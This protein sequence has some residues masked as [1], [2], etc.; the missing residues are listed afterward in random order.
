MLATVQLRLRNATEEISRFVG[1]DYIVINDSLAEATEDIHPADLAVT[2]QWASWGSGTRARERLTFSLWSKK[3]NHTTKLG[4]VDEARKA[5][6]NAVRLAP[7]GIYRPLENLGT[8]Y[9]YE[10][11]FDKAIETYEQIPPP[12]A[13]ALHATNL[14]TAYFFKGDMD[15]AAEYFA[16]AVELDPK[17]PGVRRNH[18]DVLQRLGDHEAARAEYEVAVAL[19]DEELSVNPGDGE[20]LLH[21]AM[22][23]AKAGEC[24]SSVSEA[25]KLK[26]ILPK[27]AFGAHELAYIYALCGTREEALEAVREAIDQGISP[28]LMAQEDEFASLHDDPEFQALTSSGE[29]SP[30]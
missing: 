16:R 9:L 17:D 2:G 7:D 30:N 25:N 5:F 27:T 11:N 23:S 14:A 18:G 1:Y 28:K 15:K 21:R 13:Y 26:A 6:E 24:S 29:A 8:L 22:Y 12:F 20:R 4:R 3:D 10:A 19:I